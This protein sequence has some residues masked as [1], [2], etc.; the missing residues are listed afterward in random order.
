[1]FVV[2]L[3]GAFS[4]LSLQI[5][6]DQRIGNP[7][8]WD[9]DGCR[10][11][12]RSPELRWTNAPARARSFALS[13]YDP[14]AGSAGW[15][16]WI[17]YDIPPTQHA[18]P[19]GLP[20]TAPPVVQGFNDFGTI[21]YGGPCPP[22]GDAHRYVFTLYALDVPHLSAAAPAHGTEFLQLIRRHVLATATLTGRYGR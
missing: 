21:G 15:W 3:A 9:R 19:E 8:V 10:G 6:A 22:A 17:V 14:D 7:Q 12:N 5:A 20:A 11:M 13:T 4:L 1:M 16:H 18:L 2:M